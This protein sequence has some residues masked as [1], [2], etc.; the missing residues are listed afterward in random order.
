LVFTALLPRAYV[1]SASEKIGKRPY[2]LDWAKRTEDDHPPLVDFED[3][4]GWRVETTQAVAS[5]ACSREQRIWGKFVG[6]LTYHGAGPSPVVRLIPPKPI[7][8]AQGSDAVTCWIYG[9]SIFARDKTTPPVTVS[10]AFLD[11]AGRPFQATLKTVIWKGWFLCHRRLTRAQIERVRQGASFTGLTVI[12]GRNTQDR[13]LYFDNLAVFAEPFAP[14]TFDPRPRRGVTVFPGR[15]PAL[16]TGPDALPFPTRPETIVPSNLASGSVVRVERQGSK[17]VFRYTGSDGLLTVEVPT[18]T[19]RWDGIRMRWHGRGGWIHPCRSGGVFLVGSHGKPEAPTRA[20]L[21]TTTLEKGGFTCT[22][23]V[24]S[25]DGTATVTTRY[26]MHGKS[27]VMDLAAPEAAAAEV[28]FGAAAG[29][30]KPRLVTV[31]YYTYGHSVRPAVVVAGVPDRPLFFMGHIDWTLSNASTVWA[32][33]ELST[34]RVAYNGGTRYIA[35]TDGTRN[36]CYERFVLT[37]SPR[38]EE[39]LPNIPN[40]ASPWKHVT[41]TRVWR[42]HGASDRQRDIAHWR[43][44]HRYG[45]TEL[46][47]TD[48]EGGWRDGHESF[49][50]RTRT[51]PGKGGDEGQ[52]RYARI[53]QDELGFVYGPYNNFTDF[54]P[55]NQFWHID[56]VSRTPGNHRPTAWYACYAP[57]PAR[58]PEYCAKLAPIIQKK[59]RFS[60]AYCD[61]HTAVT[62]WSRTDYDHRVPGAGTFGAV[63][64]AYGEV[65]LLQKEAWNGPVYSEGN[66]HFAYCGLADGN[67]AQDQLYGLVTAPWLVDFDLLK[68]HDLCCNFGMGAPY[69]FFGRNV[70]LGET[71]RER[72]AS[73]DRFLAATVAFGHTGFLIFQGSYRNMLRSYYLLQQLHSR[74]APGRA[75]SIHYV[76]ADGRLV[77]TSTALASGAFKRSQIVTCYDNGCTTVVNGNRTEWLRTEVHGWPV[78]L[79]PNGYLGWTEDGS[80]EVFSGEVNGHRVDYAVTPAYLYVDGRGRFTRFERAAADGVAVC[81]ILPENRYEVIPYRSRDSGF[82]IDVVSAEALDEPRNTIGSVELRRSRGLTYVVPVEGAFSYLL[83]GGQT[84]PVRSLQ[85]Q[86]DR[87]IAGETVTVRG[88]R[89]HTVGVPTSAQPGERIW[90]KLDHAWIDFTVVPLCQLFACA[91]GAELEVA[92]A[93]NLPRP[94]K[95]TIEALGVTKPIELRP[96]RP[97]TVAFALGKPIRER[98]Q[99]ADMVVEA[100]GLRLA[101]RRTLVA[102]ASYERL[103]ELPTRHETGM[104]LR[105]G[106]ETAILEG[107]GSRAYAT[108]M[109]CDGVQRETLRVIPP[110]RKGVGYTCVRFEPVL[111]P[112]DRQAA[113]RAFVGKGD[114]SALGDGILYKVAVVDGSGLETIA[115]EKKVERH[116]WLPI[117]A[118]LSSWA[119]ERVRLKL[120][121]DVGTNGNSIGDWGCWAEMR[122]ERRERTIRWRVEPADGGTLIEPGPWPIEGVK[123]AKLRQARKAW[124]HFDGS[125]LE[126]EGTAYEMYAVINGIEIGPMPRAAG[127]PLQGIWAENI[128]LPLP[129]E[130]IAALELRNEFRLENPSRDCFKLRRLWLELEL[131]DGRRASSAISAAVYT[132]PP[133]WPPGSEAAEEVAIPHG[134][135]I[136]IDL[137][138]P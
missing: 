32:E 120:I 85:C 2:E 3:V 55:L 131:A 116:R 80:I 10:A 61:V 69:M 123:S 65:L 97:A 53:M 34:D 129:R 110:W 98:I 57:K 17:V 40:P 118:D 84:K 101:E 18:E 103:G 122:L 89:E 133:N 6:K 119:G 96:D 15:D 26:W 54:A 138:F 79:P 59:F 29:L 95:G 9:N 125:G 71:E 83:Q 37:L 52:Y 137:W 12:N 33:N 135:D 43:K 81:R 106:L 76:T 92:V 130:A 5:F 23:E 42:P 16:N 63:F 62:P 19:C 39:V 94:R 35:K 27:L 41:G 114:G 20:V 47:V 77:D 1:A 49:T 72:A 91:K 128:A 67:Y 13:V 11:A 102:L 108:M 127:N 24:A 45:M 64:Y 93:S 82:A 134:R 100:D 68:M 4:G 132:Q 44:A 66:N 99:T 112:A 31:P 38:F 73:I 115:G 70:S 78:A 90:R 88:S 7:A 126:G 124:L 105:G 30:E 58:A 60:T 46:V 28:R 8:I 75:A 36:P 25:S 111:L 86:R 117:E 107:H 21:R 56:M 22:W 87:V 74:Y 109:S 50:F 121:T 113:F 48:H 51:A 136:R 14:L 104:R